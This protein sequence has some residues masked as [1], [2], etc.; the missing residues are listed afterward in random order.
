MQPSQTHEHP[1]GLSLAGAGV[2][3]IVNPASGRGQGRR[4][5]PQVEAALAGA[6]ARTQVYETQGPG[7]ATTQAQ[8]AT[9]AGAA[10]VVALGGDGT[11]HEVVNGICAAAPP[12][13]T[14]APALG[15]IPCG[16]GND[17]ARMLGLSG[18]DLPGATEAL[19]AGRL[20]RVD[21]GRIEGAGPRPEWFCNNVGLAFMAAANAAHT[22]SRLPAALSYSLGGLLA[23][24]G[25]RPEPFRVSADARAWA[26][27]LAIGQVGIGRYC[28]GGVALTPDADLS[29]GRFQ[30]FLLESRG[31]LR[32]LLAWPKVARGQKVAGTTILSGRRVKLEGPANFLIH[33]D[34]EVLRAQA[35]VLELSLVPDALRVVC[36]G[37]FDSRGR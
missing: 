12:P 10:L 34:G 27:S 33:A 13:A 19:V 15:L 29:R 9:E 31:K 1:P 11:L 36:T 23:Y 2:V 32:G 3:L 35:G 21:L 30:V 7:E 14:S 17:Y 25:F 5:L 28:G 37:E 20:R 6:G 26:G 18:R 16:T 8:R 22:E 4:A 24:L